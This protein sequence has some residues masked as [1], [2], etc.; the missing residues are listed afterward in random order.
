MRLALV[1][2][3]STC[4]QIQS[5]VA[6]LVDGPCPRLGVGL[7]RAVH[8][9]THG[10]PHGSDGETSL[11]VAVVIAM[12]RAHCHGHPTRVQIRGEARLASLS[13]HVANRRLGRLRAPQAQR[14]MGLSVHARGAGHQEKANGKRRA[15]PQLAACLAGA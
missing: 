5:A 10:A 15:R 3:S 2:E 11:K 14:V 1:S 7:L 13:I 4:C 8:D 12:A 6:V 9:P